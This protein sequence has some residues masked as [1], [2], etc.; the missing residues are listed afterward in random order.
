MPG[1]RLYRLDEAN[2]IKDVIHFEGP[3]DNAAIAEAIKVDHAAGIEI[4]NGPRKV[5]LVDPER[6]QHLRA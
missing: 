4:W 2:H 3:D 1:Y 6:R 5:A